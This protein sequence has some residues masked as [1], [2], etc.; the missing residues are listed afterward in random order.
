M[1]PRQR[2]AAQNFLF[3]IRGLLAIKQPAIIAVY[4]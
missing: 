1:E 3:V 2:A 4:Y